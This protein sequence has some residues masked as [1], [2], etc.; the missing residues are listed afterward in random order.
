MKK[1][2]L[3]GGTG[4]ESTV[5]YYREIISGV[6]DHAGLERL[7][8]IVI[9]SLSVFEVMDFCARDDLD[10]LTEYLTEA[11]VSLQ[12]AGAEIV[13]L[14]ALTPHIVFERLAKAASVPLVS[15]IEATRDVA[16]SRGIHTVALLGTKY[17]MSRDFMSRVLEAAGL[18]VVI[19][20]DDEIEYIQKHIVTEL[21]HGIVR[22]QTRDGFIK[23]IERMHTKE[24]V[25]QVILG[26]TEL[27]LILDDDSSPVPCIDPVMAHTAA[28]ATRITQ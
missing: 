13:A 15:A 18:K 20:S 16:L 8:N 26:C 1:L 6:Q 23:I 21:E 24:G 7:P 3:I 4:P 25:E 17:T 19:P 2:G 28:L 11:V 5:A 12:A 14:S 27:P 22:D 9:E 10:G